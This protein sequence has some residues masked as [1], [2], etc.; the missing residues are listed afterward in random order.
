MIDCHTLT[1]RLIYAHYHSACVSGYACTYSNPCESYFVYVGHKY[2]DDVNAQTTPNVSL[3]E[4]ERVL[5][6]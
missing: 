1:R 6:E 3:P 2:A 4:E 5:L